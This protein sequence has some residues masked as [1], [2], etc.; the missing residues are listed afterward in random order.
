MSIILEFRTLLTF[1][2]RFVDPRLKGL[3]REGF[4]ATG[5]GILP[6]A[7]DGFSKSTQVHKLGSPVDTA[8]ELKTMH[9]YT[10]RS[11]TK[12]YPY[13]DDHTHDHKTRPIIGAL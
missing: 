4:L 3:A 9:P 11:L 2:Y 10:A 8:R 1:S 12:R 5:G 7:G 6:P 13:H